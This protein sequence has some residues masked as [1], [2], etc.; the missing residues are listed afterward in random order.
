MMTTNR[1]VEMAPSHVSA[2]GRDEDWV[3]FDVE[4]S[5]QEGEPITS[6]SLFFEAIEVRAGALAFVVRLRLSA[7]R[8]VAF[9]ALVP[10][11]FVVRVLVTVDD[12]FLRDSSEVLFITKRTAFF[13]R[14][15][16]GDVDFLL[17]ESAIIWMSIR[18]W[19][20]VFQ[21]LGNS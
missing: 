8:F 14:D 4:R 19:V 1:A 18:R 5:L 13:D 3:E 9:F 16:D 20:T 21:A 7:V 2:S 10:A 6:R 11:V 15:P 12:V 17:L